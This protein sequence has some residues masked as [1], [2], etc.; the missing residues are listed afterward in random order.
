M[1]RGVEYLHPE[2]HMMDQFFF[3]L[4]APA[5]GLDALTTSHPIQVDVKDPKEIEAIFDAISYKKVNLYYYIVDQVLR[6][7]L[8]QENFKIGLVHPQHVY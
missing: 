1:C 8:M 5:L 7:I 6:L 2:W 4:T 3:D